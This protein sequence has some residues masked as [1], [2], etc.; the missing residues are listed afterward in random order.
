[1]QDGGAYYT[2]ANVARACDN[3]MSGIEHLCEILVG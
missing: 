2:C 3:S 1:M